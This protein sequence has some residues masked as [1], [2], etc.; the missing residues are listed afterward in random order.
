MTGKV[1]IFVPAYNCQDQIVRVLDQVETAWVQRAVAQVI[2]VNNRSTDDTADRV[3]ERIRIRGD[4][5]VK[6]LLNDAN[7]GLGGSHKVA[8]QYARLHGFDWIVVMHGDDQGS[9]ADFR[10]LIEEPQL[11]GIDGFM[12]S[13]FMT[14]SRSPGYSTFRIF[15]NHVFNAIYSACLCYPIRDLGSGLNIYRVSSLR[16]SDIVRFPDDL[17]FNC[18]M[19]CSQVIG[20]DKL[21]F[22][23]I[24]WREDDQVS[25]VKLVSQSFQ[26]LRIALSALTK[27]S[28]FIAAEHRSKTIDSYTWKVVDV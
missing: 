22:L 20:G 8:F 15:G 6:L 11:A 25:N 3:A 28:R 19:L 14:G 10:E 23:P 4:D 5:Y 2:V 12:G 27:K 7:Y 18:V 21:Q 16:F 17:T 13:R 24:S 26:T 1:L 9:I